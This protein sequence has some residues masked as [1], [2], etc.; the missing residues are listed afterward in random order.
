M[1]SDIFA[2]DN[3]EA[4]ILAGGA[5][6]RMGADK[7]TLELGEETFIARIASALGSVVERVRVIS[8]HHQGDLGGCEIVPDLQPQMG[9]LGGLQTALH[10][11]EKSWVFVV[12]CDLPFV[13]S[14]LFARLLAL[15]D[16][17]LKHDT[18]VEIVAPRQS[19]G[20]PQPLCALYRVAPCR[21]HIERLRQ[22]GEM[23]V[24]EM[25]FVSHTRWVEFSALADLPRS[26]FFFTN[27]N[28]PKDY[29]RA[30]RIYGN[31]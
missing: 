13:T 3:T 4:F 6:A 20:R 19:D 17:E 5:S 1:A 10:S 9:A 25:L 21:A 2:H 8:S 16:E 15:R 24:R 11:A 29:E 22:A 7:A 28:T 26:E 30:R 23:R 18:S 31:L 14:E 12:S 27:V